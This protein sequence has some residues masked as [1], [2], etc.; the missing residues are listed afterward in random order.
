MDEYHMNDGDLWM[1]TAMIFFM[2]QSRLRLRLSIVGT[3][4]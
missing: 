2:V 3:K 4:K 1:L